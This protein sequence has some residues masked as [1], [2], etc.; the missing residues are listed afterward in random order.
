MHFVF[1]IVNLL[2]YNYITMHG[3]KSLKNI[4]MYIPCILYC[5]LL[6]PTHARTYILKYFISTFTCFSASAPS[7]GSLNFVLAKVT[8]LL[9]QQQL[10][11]QLPHFINICGFY[12]TMPTHCF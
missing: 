1:Y 5:L 7:S 10:L 4:L 11:K 2:L 6:I 12:R 3:G 9:T 8:K